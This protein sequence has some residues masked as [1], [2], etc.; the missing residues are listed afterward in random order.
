MA[1][2]TGAWKD[3]EASLSNV[4]IYNNTG[5]HN[6]HLDSNTGPAGGICISAPR[7]VGALYKDKRVEL[8]N[9]SV[10]DIAVAN[11]LISDPRD[12]AVATLNDL[13]L[14]ANRIVF[15]HNLT[16]LAADKPN[17]NKMQGFKKDIQW[18]SER[19]GSLLV[20]KNPILVDPAKYDFRLL[21]GTPAVN[22]GI[23]INPDGKPD[24]TGATSYIGAFGPGANWVEAGK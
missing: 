17:L 6:G 8:K 3:A 10:T 23:A 22:G 16:D 20:T 13:D 12:Y 2:V 18:R 11:N 4:F 9:S 14:E 15:T 1:N 19:S 24:A 5:W 7:K 21:P